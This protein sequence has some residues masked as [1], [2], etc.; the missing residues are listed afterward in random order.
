MKMPFTNEQFY[1]ADQ[2]QNK[3]QDLDDWQDENGLG[4]ERDAEPLSSASG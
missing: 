3:G 2:G 4:R 1:L